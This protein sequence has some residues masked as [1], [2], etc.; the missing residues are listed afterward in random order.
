MTAK[1][2]AFIVTR[3]EKAVSVPSSNFCILSAPFVARMFAPNCVKL[4]KSLLPA[5]VDP[6]YPPALLLS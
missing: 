5:V 4:Q 2:F 3:S 1:Y 6:L